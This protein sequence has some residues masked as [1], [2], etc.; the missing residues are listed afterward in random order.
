ML[1]DLKYLNPLKSILTYAIMIELEYK[2]TFIEV[3]TTDTG[4]DRKDFSFSQEQV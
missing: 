1:S 3:K 2:L 4:A